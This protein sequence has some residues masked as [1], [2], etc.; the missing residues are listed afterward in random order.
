MYQS[1]KH[2]F[3]DIE[4]EDGGFNPGKLWRLKKK[5]WPV[6]FDPP[7]AMKNSSGG[8]IYTEDGIKKEAVSH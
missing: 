1:I 6:V 3:A 8:L 2:E 4:S 5:L 7:T